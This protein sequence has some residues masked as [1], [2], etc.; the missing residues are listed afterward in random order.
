M[1][2][3]LIASATS[4]DHLKSRMSLQDLRNR[5][6]STVWLFSELRQDAG[7]ARG[8]AIERNAAAGFAF[9]FVQF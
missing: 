2:L 4:T 7:K 5:I 8:T 3:K 6:P 9:Y 1:Q